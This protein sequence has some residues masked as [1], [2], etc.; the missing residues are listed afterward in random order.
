[1]IIHEDK[2]QRFVNP[3][4]FIP[5]AGRCERS[6]P[7]TGKESYTGYFDC[8]IRLLTPLFIP[9]T[10][11]S[12][13]L[14]KGEEKR[15]LKCQEEQWKGYD[16]F[17]YDDWWDKAMP[18]EGLPQPPKEPVIPGSEIRGAVRSVHEA[19][20]NGCL[21][22]VSM[23]RTLSRRTNEPKKPGI[24]R[25][26]NGKWFI[27]TCKKIML[28]VAREKYK[29]PNDRNGI[30]VPEEKYKDWEEGQEIWIKPG[31][32]YLKKIGG[33]DI[34][35]GT[36]AADY[37]EI[38]NSS[39]ANLNMS[40]KMQNLRKKLRTDEY[41]QGWLHKGEIFSRK[42]H[43]SVFYY[44]ETSEK[45]QVKH[46][47]DVKG[48]E[49]ILDEYR[50]PKKN[51]MLSKKGWYSEYK[52][53]EKGTLVYYCKTKDG[54]VYLSPACI[55]KEVFSKTIKE[56]LESSGGYQPCTGKELCPACQIFGMLEKAEKSN[57]N[58][59]GSRVRV[60][61]ATLIH[62]VE[63]TESLFLN[64]VI[65]PEM[66]EPKPGTVEF[67]T[68][69][70]YTGTKEKN[71]QKKGYWTYDYKY[72]I[73]NKG[74]YGEK[75]ILGRDQ[76]KLRGRKYYW[77]SDMD[78][79]LASEKF[80]ETD[81]NTVSAMKQRI[82]PLKAGGIKS[83]PLFCFRVYFEQLSKQQLGQ[84]KWALDFGNPDCAHKIGR[85]KP[86]G[87]GS[88]QIIVDA[89]NLRK[90]DMDTGRWMVEKQELEKFSIEPDAANEAVQTLQCMANW[91]K[92]PENVHYPMGE[93]ISHDGKSNANSNASHQWFTMNKGNI[94][95]PNFFKVLPKATEDALK[96]LDPNKALYKLT[97]KK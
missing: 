53:C 50:N 54:H 70:P 96:N 12:T 49:K 14:L 93:T 82:R 97:G 1:M 5:L 95:K 28:Y 79:D 78:N 67:Y 25:K 45:I 8:R 39:V 72:E 13:R 3:Y 80:K 59:Y 35:I 27:H 74:M 9:N 32:S 40:D 51:A 30:T 75:E 26:E 2:K 64:P 52:V 46:E 44:S 90:I 92:R 20:F 60:T 68:E 41:V 76:P 43:E 63:D 37:K 16:F 11:S 36:V 62:P 15:E 10:S 34:K 47:A 22:N 55:G 31:N 38:P 71:M 23:D 58:A 88:T 87:F 4:N 19:A 18:N 57:T 86:L 77:H 17:S 84:L 24:L 6:K 85:A 83:E 61:D 7:E 65:L 33:R 81:T 91:E 89:L 29:K 69:S 66:G 21:S 42:H 94:A 73:N 56:L 48:L